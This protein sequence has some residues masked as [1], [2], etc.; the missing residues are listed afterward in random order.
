MLACCSESTAMAWRSRG[1][2]AFKNEYRAPLAE[3]GSSAAAAGLNSIQR[4]A[5]PPSCAGHAASQA[6]RGGASEST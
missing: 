5:R 4:S 3:A 1:M 6:L 2:G